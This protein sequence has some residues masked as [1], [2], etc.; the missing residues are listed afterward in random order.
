MWGVGL[1]F[2]NISVEMMA[3]LCSDGKDPVERYN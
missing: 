2:K 3:C 1:T